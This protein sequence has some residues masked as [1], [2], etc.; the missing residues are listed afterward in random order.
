M[1]EKKQKKT[2]KLTMKYTRYLLS[3]RSFNLKK[4]CQS[5]SKANNTQSEYNGLWALR[6][7]N[8]KKTCQS[9]SKAN[10]TQSEYNG[11]WAERRR[12]M[13]LPGKFELAPTE[14][15]L[16]NRKKR[17]VFFLVF[18]IFFS[19]GLLGRIYRSNSNHNNVTVSCRRY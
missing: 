9:R 4:T 8:L 17:P 1:Y 18:W 7:F 13:N 11:L 10:N 5:R 19:E 16:E 15:Y 12:W 6:S 2:Q 3:L 14:F